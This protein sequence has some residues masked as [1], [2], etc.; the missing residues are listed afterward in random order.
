M[1]MGSHGPLLK[2]YVL[3]SKANAAGIAIITMRKMGA[4][5]FDRIGCTVY[6]KMGS[7]FTIG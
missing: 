1:L 6:L 5:V 7:R 3:N 4:K 2:E